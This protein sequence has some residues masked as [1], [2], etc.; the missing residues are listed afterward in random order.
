MPLPYSRKSWAFFMLSSIVALF[1]IAALRPRY[2]AL[3]LFKAYAGLK[4]EVARTYLSILWWILDPLLSMAVY[5]VVFEVLLKSGTENFVAFLLVGLVPWQ[6]FANSIQHS[7]GS[8]FGNGQLMT[9]VDLPKEIFPTIEIVMDLVKFG[10]VFMLLL[11]FLWISGFDISKAYLALPLVMAVELVLLTGFAYLAA[12]I[13]P[14]VPDLKLL[15]NA[16]LNL[17]FFLSG[18]FFSADSIPEPYRPYFYLNPMASLIEAYRAILM[19]GVW[20]NWEMLGK[21]GIVA[22]VSLYAAQWFI[23][24]FGRLYPRIVEA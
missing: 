10:F 2:L 9:Q 17:V 5:Y 18:V 21:T 4:S 11:V 19:H 22:L 7:M 1:K 20:P 13:I 24:Y 3:I 23:C 8:I 15:I 14:F 6:W 12:A 16:L